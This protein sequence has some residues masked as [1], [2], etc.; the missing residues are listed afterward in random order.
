MSSPAGLESLLL[1]PR[2]FRAG[3]S[4]TAALRLVLLWPTTN[5]RQPTTNDVLPIYLTQHN[6]YAAD[7]RHNI[8]EQPTFAHGRQ[9]L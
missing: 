7:C 5:D 1:R 6:V 2:P 9:C 3:L 4:H 8:R